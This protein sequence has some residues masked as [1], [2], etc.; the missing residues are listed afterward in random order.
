MDL[1]I[2]L[3]VPF[4]IES[5]FPKWTQVGVYLVISMTVGTLEGMRT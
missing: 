2:F 1:V 5:M 4:V 3:D